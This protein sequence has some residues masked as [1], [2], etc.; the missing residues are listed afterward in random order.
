MWHTTRRVREMIIIQHGIVF[1]PIV[2]L[3]ILIAIIFHECAHG[4]MAKWNGDLTAKFARRITLN[5]ARHFDLAGFAMLALVGFGYAKPVPVNVENFKNKKRGVVLTSLAGIK[6]NIILAIFSA[7]FLVILER[8]GAFSGS[9]S[10]GPNIGMTHLY[11]LLR[12]SRPAIGYVPYLPNA[13]YATT[14]VFGVFFFSL[15]QINIMLALFN[16]LPL[17]PLDGHRLLEQGLGSYNKVV[18]FLRDY[19]M[20]ILLV[21]VA[22]NIFFAIISSFVWPPLIN[23]SPLAALMHFGGGGLQQVFL[24]L[25]RVMFGVPPLWVF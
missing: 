18:K 23:F 11:A 2:L 7:F 4:L 12:F 5:P 9:I 24:N 8:Y 22:I 3:T 10:H 25:F 21:L 13:V 15:L 1:A 20:V 16:L 19:G 6:I 14:Y 17:W